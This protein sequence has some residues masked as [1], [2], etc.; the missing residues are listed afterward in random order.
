LNPRLPVSCSNK[1]RRLFYSREQRRDQLLARYCLELVYRGYELTDFFATEPSLFAE[2]LESG[3]R[4]ELKAQRGFIYLAVNPVYPQGVHK[5]GKT[6]LHLESRMAALTTE[7]VLGQ[8]LV[9]KAWRSRDVHR[10]E[11]RCHCALAHC[12]I[13]KEF[14]NGE[15]RKLT[16]I[17]DRVLKEERKALRQL[18]RIATEGAVAATHHL[19][20]S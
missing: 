13:E 6:R 1:L 19:L 7:G 5:V 20:M 16:R 17:I 12:A 14:F 9:V 8:Y 11:R 2:A 3:L 15:F 10:T 18:S 4:Q